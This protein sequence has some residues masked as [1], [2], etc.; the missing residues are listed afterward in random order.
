MSAKAF[1]AQYLNPWVTT[2]SDSFAGWQFVKI[3]I[4]LVEKNVIKWVLPELDRTGTNGGLFLG[5]SYDNPK[6]K[7]SSN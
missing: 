2:D 6:N 5:T 7:N 3:K 1:G 4:M